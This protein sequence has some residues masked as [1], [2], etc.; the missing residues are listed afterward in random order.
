MKKDGAGN[1]DTFL[2]TDYQYIEWTETRVFTVTSVN[3]RKSF[4]NGKDITDIFGSIDGLRLQG[5]RWLKTFDFENDKTHE[6]YIN[7]DHIV[8]IE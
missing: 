4:I 1:H 8:S 2:D 5:K 3:G 7:I 6:V